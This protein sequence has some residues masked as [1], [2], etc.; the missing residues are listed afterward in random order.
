MR[1]ILGQP[2]FWVLLLILAAPPLSSAQLFP[3]APLK[4]RPKPPCELENPVHKYYREQFWGHYPTC[5]RKWPTGWGCPSAE[6]PNWELEK[7]KTPLD[8]LEPLDVDE[9]EL[10]G[11]EPGPERPGGRPAGQPVLPDLPGEADPFKDLLPGG[12]TKPGGA[13]DP[14]RD[15]LPGGGAR[16]G[17]NPG[18]MTRIDRGAANPA[19][20]V[21]VLESPPSIPSGGDGNAVESASPS[22][23]NSTPSADLLPPAIPSARANG[24]GSAR[25]GVL[26]G[27]FRGRRG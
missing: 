5:W 24:A 18:G 22:A 17:G 26:A 10:P 4:K 2:L 14:F 7:Q 20:E 12:N 1:R 15:L 21:P 16:P 3:N 19:G 27:L 13:N 9:A 25:R 6:K 8:K 11:M 23:A